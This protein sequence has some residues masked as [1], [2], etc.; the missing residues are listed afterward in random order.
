MRKIGF[1]RLQ[2]EAQRGYAVQEWIGWD[3]HPPLYFRISRL[4]SLKEPEKI[5]HPLIRS[6]KD[7]ILGFLKIIG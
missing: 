7:N 5:R 3:P 6:I 4:E 2:L 1:R